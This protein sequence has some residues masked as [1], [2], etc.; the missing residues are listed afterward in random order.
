MISGGFNGAVIKMFLGALMIV[1]GLFLI[2]GT[3]ALGV[4][5]GMTM[6]SF[7][8]AMFLQGAA[9]YFD[10]LTDREAA[11]FHCMYPNLILSLIT[12]AFASFF[13]PLAAPIYWFELEWFGN[14]QTVYSIASCIELL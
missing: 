8:L 9:T 12:I 13:E 6:I 10:S 7:G 3:A 14:L 11:Y 4:A 5:A 1:I 2:V